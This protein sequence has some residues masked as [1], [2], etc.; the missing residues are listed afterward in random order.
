[1][2]QP[3]MMDVNPIPGVH[4]PHVHD[5]YAACPTGIHRLLAVPTR[6]LDFPSI[7]ASSRRHLAAGARQSP[8]DL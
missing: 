4:C 1:M 3:S 6:L 5:S 8:V 7:L 2:R